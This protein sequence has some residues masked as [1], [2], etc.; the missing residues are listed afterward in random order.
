MGYEFNFFCYPVFTVPKLNQQKLR[1]IQI[2]LPPL[3]EQKR[4]V[5]IL[6]KTSYRHRLKSSFS[7]QKKT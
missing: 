2:P 4:I 1:Q 6:D 7:S 5:A 3:A